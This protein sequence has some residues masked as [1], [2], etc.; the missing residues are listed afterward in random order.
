MIL[1]DSTLVFADKNS[2]SYNLMFKNVNGYQKLDAQIDANGIVT[3]GRLIITGYKDG[4]FSNCK[5]YG[6]AGKCLSCDADL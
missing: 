6:P 1:K 3:I 5:K 4:D 2:N